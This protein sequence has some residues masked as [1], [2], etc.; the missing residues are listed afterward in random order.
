[1]KSEN[2]GPSPNVQIPP[3]SDV[4]QSHENDLSGWI[5]RKAYYSLPLLA[6]LTQAQEL[7]LEKIFRY[8]LRTCLGLSNNCPNAILFEI[9][10]T[11]SLWHLQNTKFAYASLGKVLAVSDNL[12]YPSGFWDW[13]L[14][15]PS[16][17]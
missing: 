11:A 15:G 2:E 4:S 12:N 5:V 13:I 9:S 7:K 1:M 16:Y 10:G 14:S 8:A 17:D 6:H 3:L